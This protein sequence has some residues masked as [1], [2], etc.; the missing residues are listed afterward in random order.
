MDDVRAVMDAVGSER[1]LLLGISEGGPMAALFAATY[2]MRTAGLVLMGSYARWLRAPD[3]PIGSRPED[4][5]SANIPPE[6]WGLPAARAVRRRACA[7]ARRRRGRLSVV[8]LVSRPRRQPR[9]GGAPHAHEHGDRRAPRPP[10]DPRADA[11][12]LPRAGVPAR[13]RPLHGRADPGR[14]DRRAPGRRPSAVGGRTGRRPRRD[15]AVRGRPR[16]DARSPNACSPRSSSS[17]RTGPRRRAIWFAPTSRA[18]TAP[19]SR[20]PTTRSSHGS[21]APRARSAAGRR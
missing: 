19:S 11:R 6:D 21:T 15:R 16:R 1:A 18:S 20:S 7:V 13:R 10:V 9:R 4:A 12:A 14:A 8:R 2:P 3:Y 5:L 17:R